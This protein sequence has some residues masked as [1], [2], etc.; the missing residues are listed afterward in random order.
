MRDL[1]RKSAPSKRAAEMMPAE[2]PIAVIGLGILLPDAASL[3]DLHHNLA[4]GRDSVGPLG[5]DRRTL[6]GAADVEE[7][8]PAA[9]VEGIEIFD[10]EYFGISP[11]EAVMMDPH[12]RVLLH[13]VSQAC[14]D[15]GYSRR[16]LSEL[17]VSVVFSAPRSH[18]G[19]LLEERGPLRML[20]TAS[21]A[22]AGRVAYLFG[23]QGSTAVIDAGCCGS[24][25]AI[26]NACTEL[27]AGNCDLVIAG[28]LHIQTRV[29]SYRDAARYEQLMA[30]DGRCRAFDAAATGT[31][32]GE[33]G[34]VVLLRRL[35]DAIAAGDV[36][37][38]VLRGVSV[39]HNGA[40]AN[41]LASPSAAAEAEVMTAAWRQAGLDPAE[42][43]V[44]EAHGS[45]TPL[46][47]AVEIEAIRRVRP[48]H[49]ATAPCSIGSIKTNIGHLDHAAG[50][51]GLMKAVAAVKYGMHYPSLH[52][53]QAN[54]LLELEQGDLQ[55]STRARRWIETNRPRRMGVNSFSLTGT[56]VHAVVEQGP[57]QAVRERRVAEPRL[58]IVTLSGHH[59][60]V[61]NGLAARLRRRLSELGDDAFNDIA[62]TL[63]H[64]RDD[65][66]FRRAFVVSGTKVLQ[67]EL[68]LD[69]RPIE[70]R[71][72]QLLVIADAWSSVLLPGVGDR[73][74]TS[75]ATGAND[76]ARLIESH[77]VLQMP[78]TASADGGECALWD[79]DTVSRVIAAEAQADTALAVLLIGCEKEVERA[80]KKAVGAGSPL[81]SLSSG[82]S[83]TETMHALAR[84]YEVGVNINWNQWYQGRSNRRVELPSHPWQGA[85]FWPDIEKPQQRAALEAGVPPKARVSEEMPTTP[86][87][88]IPGWSGSGQKVVNCAELRAPEIAEV[89]DAVR[90]MWQ[91]ALGRPAVAADDD[92]FR[93]GGNSVIGLGVV[94]AIYRRFGV[95]IR[96]PDIYENSIASALATHIRARIVTGQQG[97]DAPIPRLPGSSELLP[98]SFGQES[99]WVLETLVPDSPIYSV[100]TDLHIDGTINVPALARAIERLVERH[101]VLRTTYV[102]VDGRPHVR[103]L[104]PSAIELETYDIPESSRNPEQDAAEVLRASVATPFNLA[105]GPLVRPLLVRLSPAENILLFNL[106]H[107]V[108]DGW[109]PPIL[110]RDLWTLYESELQ[111]TDPQLPALDIQYSD[112]A[113]WQR[114][115]YT[116]RRR[117]AELDFWRKQLSGLATLDLPTDRPRPPQLS[118]RGAHYWFRIPASTVARLRAYAANERATLFMTMFTA[119]IMVISRYARQDDIPVG[120][121]TAGRNRPETQELFGYFNNAVVLRSSAEGNPSFN[122]LMQR[123]RRMLL[124]TLEHDD[125][126]FAD[127]VATLLQQ[128]DLS[129]HPLF[130]VGYT[131]QNLTRGRDDLPGNL[132]VNRRRDRLFIGLPPNTAKWDLDLGVV[133][134]TGDRSL[135]AVLEYSTD[136]FDESS[137]VA[138]SRSLLATYDAVMRDP[139]LRLD[140]LPL[141]RAPAHERRVARRPADTPSRIA[142]VVQRFEHHAQQQPG[143]MALTDGCSRQTYATLAERSATIASAIACH[144][145]GPQ[146]HVAVLTGRYPGAVAAILGCWKAACISVPVDSDQPDARLAAILQDANATILI[147]VGETAKVTATR[148]QE[149]QR[150]DVI[151]VD[152]QGQLADSSAEKPMELRRPTEDDGAYIIYTSGSTGTPKGVLV[153]HK[154]LATFCDHWAE[155]EPESLTYLTCASPGFDV[156]VGDICRSVVSGGGLVIPE[157]ET[158]AVPAE[159]Y[160]LMAAEAVQAV[161]FV[162]G[163]VREDLREY[164]AA[165]GSQLPHLRLIINGLD[166]WS[167]AELREAA[168][169]FGARVLNIYGVTEAAIDSATFQDDGTTDPRN[170]VPVG[171]PN[172]GAR[173]YVLDAN[174]RPVPP[175]VPGELYVAG[176]GLAAGYWNRMRQTAER[177]LPD[178]FVSTASGRMYRTGDRARYLADGSIDFLGRLDSQV[179][180]NGV[181][182]ELEEIEAVLLAHPAVSEAAVIADSGAAGLVLRAF[183]TANGRLEPAAAIE[184]LSAKLPRTI[185]PASAHALESL[186]KTATGKVDRRQLIAGSAPGVNEMPSRSRVR[187]GD[188]TELRMLEI[189]SQLLGKDDMSVTDDFFELGGHSL[190]GVRV[191]TEVHREFQVRFSLGTLFERRTVEALSA[192]V[193]AAVPTIEGPLIPIRREGSLPPLY[194]VHPSGG[195]VFCYYNFAQALEWDR[196]I[197]GIQS[198]PGLL[199]RSGEITI[200]GLATEYSQVIKE[201]QPEGP[202]HLAG[203][204]LGGVLAFE[205]ARQL[206]DASESIAYL[207]LFDTEAIVHESSI[208]AATDS[209]LL[210]AMLVL[211]AGVDV[212]EHEI[213]DLDESEKLEYLLDIARKVDLFSHHMTVEEVTAYLTV[214]R[215]NDNALLQYGFGAFAGDAILYKASDTRSA[216]PD[217]GWG[218]W[219]SGS[220]KITT[221]PGDHYSLF[222]EHAADIA[223]A[224]KNDLDGARAEGGRDND[225]VI[226]DYE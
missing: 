176:D 211:N 219:I 147:A 38:A 104:P 13:L 111:G 174:L 212:G 199:E 71:P 41:G 166:V 101:E 150:L 39:N 109:S 136:L 34:A 70:S 151:C 171:R 49:I 220:V 53:D 65:H 30:N 72:R 7:T 201:Y 149:S 226:A 87:A 167:L 15:A 115:Q 81:E 37:H 119:F 84:L 10:N 215:R 89:V 160:A 120:I 99:L 74:T 206:S 8:Y 224:V 140:D 28:G 98:A 12:Q 198:P 144:A 196:P 129:R 42:L 91:V 221:V 177:F 57:E 55:V 51:A 208:A 202:Y 146:T 79:A 188:A 210:K 77:V 164:L 218:R 23:C 169:V 137:I 204:S 181:R 31:S 157:V 143:Q 76:L 118:G 122:D 203:W 14:E 213:A 19:D 186:P 145:S 18:Y 5:R 148:L 216:T 35:E 159:L 27:R 158:V 179:K 161:E 162:P 52:F 69:L 83:G 48:S 45:G 189:W 154:A 152:R 1:E 225:L 60:D 26:Y 121:T 205:M 193:R 222:R 131:H 195:N 32:D 105:S 50:I 207:G 124:D 9:T 214:T 75:P 90:Q 59:P 126:P 170:R 173:L 223:R 197:V 130:Q 139:T 95:L 61:V 209:E 3:L 54:P 182:V 165:S 93:L 106:H 117:E 36:I 96:L 138:L 85:R 187:P 92:Y 29:F 178:P 103:L 62:Y 172:V 192:A 112:F 63:N 180:V 190:L 40:R 128:R 155:M 142:S 123:T 132:R 127:V 110:R 2:D 156:F 68:E 24:L 153:Q 163:S 4:A 22:L 20:G 80:A 6:L 67:D 217:L 134:Y 108:D 94:D 17:L 191:L 114:Q 47:D 33:G 58:D 46:G 200:S 183:Y 43:D 100:P 66:V 135:N 97:S 133:E 185:V 56:N 141:A 168:R 125:T 86:V 88:A 64:G 194:C 25:V 78:S 16:S 107:S 102:D 184:F 116:G 21:A 73:P 113:A 11:R 175:S 44:L 82:A